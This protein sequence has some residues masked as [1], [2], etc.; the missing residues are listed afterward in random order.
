MAVMSSNDRRFCRW[1]RRFAASHDRPP[2][3]PED[4]HQ[5]R[6]ATALGAFSASQSWFDEHAVG[7]PTPAERRRER[8]DLQ[9]SE[10]FSANDGE[11]GSPRVRAEL[12]EREEWSHLSVNTVAKRMPRLAL[13]AKRRRLRRSLT[14][15]NENAK[16][17]PT[18]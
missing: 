14:R 11:S 15:P 16:A 3:A 2:Q 7:E 8:L 6:L 12:S 1:T 17:F 5:V 9:I 10:V 13:G 4:P 18:S